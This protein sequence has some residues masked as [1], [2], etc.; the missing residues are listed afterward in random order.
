MPPWSLC[1]PVPASTGRCCCGAALHS[2]N[3]N[4]STWRTDRCSTKRGTVQC[5][6]QLPSTRTCCTS[7]GDRVPEAYAHCVTA[8]CQVISNRDVP[9][10]Y[11]TAR[12]LNHEPNSAAQ[13]LLP[14]TP[15][16]LSQL[17]HALTIVM[18]F[19]KGNSLVFVRRLLNCIV[20]AR[21]CAAVCVCVCVCMYVCGVSGRKCVVR[22]RTE[23]ADHGDTQQHQ[24]TGTDGLPLLA[25]V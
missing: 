9:P 4:R 14:T 6:G 5:R 7:A 15:H 19:W 18:F 21:Q 16:V 13:R 1:C 25:Y 10:V 24:G 3:Q 17:S 23:R 2:N 8:H 12:Q 22:A 20:K 11:Y